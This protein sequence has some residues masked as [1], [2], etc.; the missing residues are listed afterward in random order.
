MRRE[1]KLCPLRYVDTVKKKGQA[2]IA[3]S[4]PQ[5]ILFNNGKQ[6]FS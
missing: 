1:D 2:E 3:Q 5:I 6:I 4:H